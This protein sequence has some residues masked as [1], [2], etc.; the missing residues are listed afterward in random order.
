MLHQF[1]LRDTHTHSVRLLWTRDR[2]VAETS[3]TLVALLVF[4]RFIRSVTCV[5]GD[6]CTAEKHRAVQNLLFTKHDLGD[7]CEKNSRYWGTGEVQTRVWWGN[8][9]ERGYLEDLNWAVILHWI[10][11]L[12]ICHAIYL[13]K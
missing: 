7:Q 8:V 10:F 12:Y 2:P 9:R 5:F 11:M 4:K 13:C 1:T 6:D 3:A